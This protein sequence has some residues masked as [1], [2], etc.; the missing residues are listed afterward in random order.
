MGRQLK[1]ERDTVTGQIIPAGSN[2]Y[3]KK[4][5]WKH[6]I[7][8]VTPHRAQQALI[9]SRLQHVFA[10]YNIDGSLIRGAVDTV[11]RFQGQ[12]RDI[13]IASYALGDEDAIRGEEEFLMSLN[14]FN[15]MVS[16]ARAKI[17]VLVSQEVIKHLSN[18]IDVLRQSRLIKVY[19]DSFCNVAESIRLG[20]V[21]DNEPRLIEG[22]LKHHRCDLC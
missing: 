1:N 19:A 18:D 8:I 22:L 20:H 16:R 17:I 9:V 11:E 15:V 21:V 13:I 2:S 7:G 4:A 10:T 3:D 14:R 5:F 6:G 12:Q